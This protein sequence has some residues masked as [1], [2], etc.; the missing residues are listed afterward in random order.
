MAKDTLTTGKLT[1]NAVEYAVT[2]F[3]YNEQYDEVDVTDT[4]T[5]GD[6]KEYLGGRAERTFTVVMWRD[7]G[8]A[9]PPRNSAQTMELDFEGLTYAGTGIILSMQV[10]AS[11]DNAIQMTVTGRFNGTVTETVVS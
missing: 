9:A 4:G 10:T 7:T 2:S 5:T 8:V 11:T 3:D 1:F 6:G